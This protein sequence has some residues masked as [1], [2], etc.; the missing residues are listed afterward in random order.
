MALQGKVLV[1][2]DWSP[3]FDSWI[4]QEK[5]DAAFG[6]L[7]A[8]LQRSSVV[9]NLGHLLSLLVYH[10]YL[11]YFAQF[12]PQWHQSHVLKMHHQ[13]NQWLE[14]QSEDYRELVIQKKNRPRLRWSPLPLPWSWKPLK[15]HGSKKNQ[16]N[17]KLLIRLLTPFCKCGNWLYSENFLELPRRYWVLHSLRAAMW[18]AVTLTTS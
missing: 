18:K 14:I 2:Q 15:S 7:G 9:T 13:N 17:I 12:H 3:E 5:L 6:F 16:E 8:L 10:C 1:V 11:H 4:P